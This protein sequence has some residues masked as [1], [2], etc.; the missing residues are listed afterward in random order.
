MVTM[1]AQGS[2]YT[3]VAQDGSTKTHFKSGYP[4]YSV[5]NRMVTMTTLD[6]TQ[7]GTQATMPD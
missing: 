7:C 2:D 6:T 3:I 5:G 1:D 4:G